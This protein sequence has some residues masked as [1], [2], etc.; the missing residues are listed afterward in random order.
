M[1]EKKKTVGQISTELLQKTPDSLSPIEN[2]REQL[3]DWDQNMMVCLEQA[4]KDY[5]GDFF[6]Q[7]ITKKEP[8]LKNVLRNYFIA[9]QSC[10]TPGYDQSVFHYIRKDDEVSFL[11]VVPSKDTCQIFYANRDRIVPQEWPLLEYVLK[12]N[13]GTLEKQCMILNG[14]FD[15]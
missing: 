11:W 6:I 7:V 15:S 10:P 13:D 14:E 2:M 1:P 9:R 12:F 3:T 8:L 4:K 5:A